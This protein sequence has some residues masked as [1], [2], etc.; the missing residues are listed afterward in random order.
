[1][2]TDNWF[3]AI[4]FLAVYVAALM[5]LDGAHKARIAELKQIHREQVSGLRSYIRTL[6]RERL[7]L[8]A[9]L[10][11]VTDKLATVDK[12]NKVQVEPEHIQWLP[13]WPTAPDA[14]EEYEEED[15]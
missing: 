11:R 2:S 4:C 7:W 1:M 12:R 14:A 8:E 10:Q 3:A 6:S 9:E 13:P 15:G 5:L